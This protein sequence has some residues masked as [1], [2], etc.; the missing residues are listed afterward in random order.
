MQHNVL[1]CRPKPSCLRVAWQLCREFNDTTGE[2]ELVPSLDHC[3]LEMLCLD[4][5]CALLICPETVLPNVDGQVQH[6]IRGDGILWCVV[7]QGLVRVCRSNGGGISKAQTLRYE[8]GDYQRQDKPNERQR[9]RD[10]CCERD[11]SLIHSFEAV[12]TN[13]IDDSQSFL[14]SAVHLGSSPSSNVRPS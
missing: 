6:T 2:T 8:Q 1:T 3:R 9:T 12:K 5:G 11:V 13:V 10:I 7:V 14:F 4:V